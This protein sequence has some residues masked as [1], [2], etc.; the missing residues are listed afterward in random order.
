MSYYLVAEYRTLGVLQK[1]K[2][3]YL[4]SW[5]HVQY[6]YNIN[7]RPETFSAISRHRRPAICALMWWNHATA[8]PKPCKDRLTT[9]ILMCYS[10]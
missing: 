6:E 5:R 10:Q 9:G 8:V 3:S 2:L 1:R 4:V 7:D